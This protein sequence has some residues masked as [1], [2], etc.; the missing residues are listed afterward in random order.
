MKFLGIK[1]D[2]LNRQDAL[3]KAFNFFA[4]ESQCVI[5][6]PNPEIIVDSHK[7]SYLAKV[8]NTGD[9][10]IC[11]GVGLQMAILLKQGIKIKRL[12]GVDFMLAMC[13]K[14]SISGKTVF[15]LGS[16]NDKVVSR[17]ATN[18][19]NKFGNLKIVGISP[20]PRI[21]IKDDAL[22]M[23]HAENSEIIAQ[24]NSAPP[25]ILFVAFGHN[26]Q[27]KWIF[28]NIS[29]IPCVKIVMAVGG[30]FDFISGHV[31]RAPL[32]IRKIGLEWLFR[33]FI[34]PRRI[35]RILKATIIFIIL[36]CQAKQ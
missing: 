29:K 1:I 14:A 7:D 17:V 25:D 4:N 22:I 13:Q 30:S 10:N 6:T 26:K 12:A 31:T 15:L 5:Y 20:G 16:D 2:N 32:W 33:L 23:D 19:K 18:L 21:S 27:E 24:I 36:C 11:D 34:Q 9:I 28:E 35:L 8:L 3:I